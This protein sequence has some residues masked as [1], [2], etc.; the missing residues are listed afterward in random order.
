[1]NPAREI[2]KISYGQ[3]VIEENRRHFKEY[4]RYELG[5]TQKKSI[6]TIRDRYYGVKEFLKYCDEKTYIVL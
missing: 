1:M 6:Q 3:I 4:M 5:V 2:R